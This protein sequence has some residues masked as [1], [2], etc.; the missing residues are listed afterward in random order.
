M[1]TFLCKVIEIYCKH[2]NWNN[3]GY[4][5]Q[6]EFVVTLPDQLADNRCHCFLK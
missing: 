4:C 5:L 2:I 6:I 3:D 1:M